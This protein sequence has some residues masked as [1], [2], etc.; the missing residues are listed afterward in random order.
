MTG[1]D[2]AIILAP[3]LA[4]VAFIEALTIATL[5]GEN[6]ELQ[7]KYDTMHEAANR[8]IVA[9]KEAQEQSMRALGMRR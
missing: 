4:L 6:R 8:A 1:G 2:L 5:R 9:A 3:L 7:R